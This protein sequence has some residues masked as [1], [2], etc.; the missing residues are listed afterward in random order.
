[1]IM[2]SA[3]E[4]RQI[5]HSREAPRHHRPGRRAAWQD[6]GQVSYSLHM[7]TSGNILRI[8]ALLKVSFMHQSIANCIRC[9]FIK[10]KNSTEEKI[11][12]TISPNAV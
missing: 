5:E 2:T 3:R 10:Y 12:M 4:E 1:M 6:M 8:C 7:Y 11:T 9:P